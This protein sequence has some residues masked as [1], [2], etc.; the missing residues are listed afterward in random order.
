MFHIVI[1]FKLM[2]SGLPQGIEPSN[3]HRLT[4]GSLFI[5]IKDAYIHNCLAAGCLMSKPQ[6]TCNRFRHAYMGDSFPMQ[7]VISCY[8]QNTLVGLS[9]TLPP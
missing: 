4:Y 9:V 2:Y 1:F 5:M 8:L 7:F 3:G 6:P